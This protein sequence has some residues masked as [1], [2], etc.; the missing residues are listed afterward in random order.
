MK[1]QVITQVTQV[2]LKNKNDNNSNKHA[3]SKHF[4]HISEGEEVVAAPAKYVFDDDKIR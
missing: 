3:Y 1:P 4:L 2:I